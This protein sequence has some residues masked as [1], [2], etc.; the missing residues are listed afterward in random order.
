[1][2]GTSE[3]QVHSARR[4]KQAIGRALIPNLPIGRRSFDILRYE[5]GCL[6]RRVVNVFSPRYR[7]RIRRL[8]AQNG[9]SLNLGSGGKGLPGWINID[10]RW[11]A[12][13]YVACDIRRRLPLRDGQVMRLFA[14]HVVEHLDFRGDIPVVFGEFYRVLEPGG[15]VRIIVPDAGRFAEAYANLSREAAFQALGWD[16]DNLPRDIHTPMHVLNHIFHQSGEHLF[17]WDFDTMRLLLNQ[18]GFTHV[19]R[20]QY[21]VSS[22]PELAIDQPVHRAYS[23][24]VEARK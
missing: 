8:R 24:V 14:E 10:A 1:M 20:Q 3:P 4:I 9:I 19:S 21:R 16:L 23:L 13:C 17:G 12:D 15:T 18:A 2:T 7:A 11:S 6:A 22:D 5:F